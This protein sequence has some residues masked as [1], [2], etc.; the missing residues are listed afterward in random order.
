MSDLSGPQRDALVAY[1]TAIA[2]DELVLGHR[3]SEWTGLGPVLEADIALSSIAQD[4]LGHARVWY[5]LLAALT[6]ATPD[7]M[8]FQRPWHAFRNAQL[9]ELPRGD[10]AFTVVRHYLHDAAEQARLEA[11]AEAAYQPVAQVARKL[12]VEEKY[13]L[14]HGR[15][16]IT[17]LG[18][19]TEE[20][21]RRMQVAL[22]LAYPYALGLFE[23]I[24]GEEELV[25]ARILPAS[26]EVHARWEYEAGRFLAQVG[27]RLPL[28]AR[29]VLGG[30]QGQHTDHLQALVEALQ[31]VARIAP[32]GTW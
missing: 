31:L 10:W 5:E 25:A 28:P 2:D 27:L 4:E 13:H 6:G 22:D 12:R 17:K 16:W 23:P 29:A 7:E 19:A 3:A 20:S 1:I 32:P 14:L 18:R 15:S 11:L 26:G 24:E 8:V 21:A 9:S 30:R